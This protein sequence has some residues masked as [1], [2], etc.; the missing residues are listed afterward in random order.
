[1][2]RPKNSKPSYVSAGVHSTVAQSTKR[3]VRAGYMQ[4]AER[5]LNVLNAAR[6]GRNT[7]ITIENPNKEETNRPFIKVSGR[8]YFRPAE[9]PSKK[10]SGVKDAA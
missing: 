7:S 3:A 8:D 1:M 9:L 10:D 5:M 6:K 4:S 2:G